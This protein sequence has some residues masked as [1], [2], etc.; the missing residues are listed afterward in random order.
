MT[1]I[2][3]K[4]WVMQ[5]TRVDTRDC[6]PRAQARGL[7][8]LHLPP[9]LP[10]TVLAFVGQNENGILRRHSQDFI[11]LVE[12]YGFTGHI[13]DLS[14]LDWPEQLHD[15][16]AQGVL[17]AWG[18]AGIGSRLS[19]GGALLW[20]A[21]G[22]PFISMLSDSPS[23]MPANH[24]VPSDFV[25]NG[26]VFRDWL[27]VQRRLIRSPQLSALLPHGIVGNPLRD[28]LAW[29]DRPHRMVFVKTGHAPELHRA[30]WQ[31][32][33]PRFRAV[34]EDTSA[35][36]LRAGVGD[37][38]QILLACLDHHGLYLERHTHMLFALMR[39]VDV[40]VR[41]YRSTAMALAL[42]HLPVDIIGRGW[43][44]VERLG[45]KARFHQAVDAATLPT[46]YSQ[47]QFLLNTMPNFATCTH[48]RVLH[49]FAAKCCVVTN[50]NSFMR[51]RFGGLPSYFGVDTE[52]TD[53]EERL[54]GLCY[55]SKRYDDELQPAL[56]LVQDEFSAASMMRGMIDLALE[57]RTAATYAHFKFC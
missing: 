18:A 41:D 50:E 44:H 39:E 8:D 40:Y 32:L 19:P 7:D 16:L 20:D 47:T 48:E 49:G 28:A 43:D 25:A 6:S 56:D 33:P 2:Q 12:P 55:G 30:Q 53:L 35:A 36:V 45:G 34:I 22:V 26:Y 13:L 23:W 57:V 10:R 42:R 21:V 4:A 3:Q 9:G 17:F 5:A 11:D 15:L 1:P 24:H 37:I 52:A 29:S 31:A 54:A 46:L 14:G 27:N 51:E 38:T